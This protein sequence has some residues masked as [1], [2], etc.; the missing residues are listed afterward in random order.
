MKR[1]ACLSLMAAVACTAPDAGAPDARRPAITMGAPEEVG[2]SAEVLAEIGPAM[3]A[4]IEEGQTGGIVT[5]V[6][7]DGVVV[8]WEAHGWRVLGE[9]PLERDDVFRIYSMTK[10]VTSVAAMMLVEEGRLALDQPLGDILPVFA[11]VQ[12]YDAGELRPPTRS[13]TI[14]DLLR[15]TSGLTY[16][17]FG[18]T[19]VDRMYLDA[20]QPLEM[21]AGRTLA[22]TVD[23]VAELPLLADPGTL[24]NYSMSTD[25]LG[26]VVEV[27]SGMSLD[28]FFR[29]RI[30]EPLG[31]QNTAFHVADE[32]H[33]RLLDVYTRQGG[34]LI[35]V[36][37]AEDSPF[38][39]PPSWYS[40]G[41]GL[42]STP[43]DYLKFAQMLA[44]EGELDGVR[45]LRSET[46][47][48][49]T[50][51]QL[52]GALLPMRL[53]GPIPSHGW[54][55]GFAVGMEGPFEDI[56]WWAGI[57]NTRFWIDPVEGI[58]AFAWTQYL[59]S[60]GV[61]LDSVLRGIVYGSLMESRRGD[62]ALP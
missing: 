12:V 28:D 57:A 58:V 35:A 40:G 56:Y 48:A 18:N 51:N 55:M 10:P 29:T 30:F 54:G 20:L 15:H 37:A 7:R 36:D 53:G 38:T 1:L 43:S 9:D 44:N 2:L 33:H 52:D 39:E 23:V 8:H 42:T 59:P 49:M 16:G 27:A 21:D 5:L 34:R 25:V 13:I 62:P 19:P 14:R 24:W 4:V 11:D 47:R 60:G 45:L 61:D 32:D 41:G 17:M 3:E 31:I 46:V 22:E 50:T 6:A 26:R